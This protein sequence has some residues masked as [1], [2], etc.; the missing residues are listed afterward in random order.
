ME[1]PQ[2][3]EVANK[4]LVC[5]LHKALYCLKQAP[6]TWFQKLTTTLHQ[7]DFKSSRC[8][9]SLF[10]KHSASS[11][12]LIL[13]YVDDIIVTGTSTRE[14]AAVVS[15]LGS[16]FALK[17]LGPLHYFIG[18]EV[19]RSCIGLIHLNQTKYATEI[20]QK[21]SMENAKS[22]STPMYVSTRLTTKG[23]EK[24]ECQPLSIYYWVTTIFD[25]HK[26]KHCLQ[27]Q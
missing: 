18:V 11:T 8:D 14:I 21:A 6:R 13:V 5:K 27:C 16:A 24:F 4:S 19:Q 7:M 15:Q 2:G 9:F 17:D 12:I 26:T 10:I 1:Q 3:F 25:Y 23:E 22:S 20:L